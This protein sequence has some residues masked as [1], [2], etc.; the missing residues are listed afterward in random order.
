MPRVYG[1]RASDVVKL[2]TEDESLFAIFDAETGA[3]A[4]E[5][6]YAF[7]HEL[8]QTLADCMLRRTM[9]GLNSTCGLKAVERAASVAQ[10]YLGWTD[11]RVV[12]E[13]EDYLRY[14]E[15]FRKA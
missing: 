6:V 10:R 8:A 7:K 13:V 15:R 4:A 2:T 14:V 3:I 11:S 12:R 1:A 9:V 5:V